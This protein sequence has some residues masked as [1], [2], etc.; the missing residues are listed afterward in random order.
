MSFIAHKVPFYFCEV[1]TIQR[2]F[3]EEFRTSNL[4]PLTLFRKREKKPVISLRKTADYRFRWRPAI[5]VTSEI[6]GSIFGTV[7]LIG[8]KYFQYALS[9]AELQVTPCALL[10][11]LQIS[12][13][14]TETRHFFSFLK[15][16]LKFGTLK[17]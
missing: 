7:M 5:R 2:A 17:K 9:L 16:Q 11:Q 4:H 13:F 6:L 1:P 3:Q 8:T 15:S 12:L 10:R 14:K